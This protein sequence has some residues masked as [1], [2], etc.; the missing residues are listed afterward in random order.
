M[1]PKQP[2]APTSI[3]IHIGTFTRATTRRAG[4][5]CRVEDLAGPMR[6]FRP[7]RARQFLHRPRPLRCGGGGAL[8]STPG[9]SRSGATGLP[10]ARAPA[11]GLQDMMEPCAEIRMPAPIRSSTIAGHAAQQAMARHGVPL[12]AAGRDAGRKRVA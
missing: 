8:P 3:E 1:R 4:M 12:T 7:K 2:G 5:T 9:W 6:R 10:V 11:Q